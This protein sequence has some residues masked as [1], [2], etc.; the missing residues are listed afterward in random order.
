MEIDKFYINF[1]KKELAR[2]VNEYGVAKKK[3]DLSDKDYGE[4]N[5]LNKIRAEEILKIL[6][7]GYYANEYNNQIIVE[8]KIYI[9]AKKFRFKG[10]SK[11]YYR[12]KYFIENVGVYFK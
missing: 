6:K 9:A 8:D 5:P 10:K 1:W 11:W 12:P 4:P 7:Q 2:R 3:F